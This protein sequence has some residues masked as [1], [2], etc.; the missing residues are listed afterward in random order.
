MIAKK[1]LHFT[2]EIEDGSYECWE[3]GATCKL[4]ISRL[5]K[6]EASSSKRGTKNQKEEMELKPNVGEKIN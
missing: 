2:V 1:S 3:K 6:P 5:G 4:L